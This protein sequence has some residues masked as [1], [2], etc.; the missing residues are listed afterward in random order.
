MGFRESMTTLIS[1]N[2]LVPNYLWIMLLPM[3]IQ[4][5]CYVEIFSNNCYYVCEKTIQKGE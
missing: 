2:S 3:G 1:E 5:L 4:L